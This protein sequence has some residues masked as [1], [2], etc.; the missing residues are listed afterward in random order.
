MKKNFL[1]KVHS[2]IEEDGE[3]LVSGIS[4]K[5]MI[6]WA[7]WEDLKEEQEK[8]GLKGGDDVRVAGYVL[9]QL[10]IKNDV[11]DVYDSDEKGW[12]IFWR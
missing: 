6:Y 7:Y 5:T 11:V 3:P 8:R 2:I 9:D 12:K 1:D 4:S 10:G